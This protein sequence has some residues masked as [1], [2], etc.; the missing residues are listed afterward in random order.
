MLK[1]DWSDKVK[2]TVSVESLTRRLILK[3]DPGYPPYVYLSFVNLRTLQIVY[4]DG[5]SCQVY[6]L[7]Q[8]KERV[9]FK[10]LD[11]KGRFN[12]FTLGSFNFQR[13]NG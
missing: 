4:P 6:A 13:V 5:L 7:A 1:N 2:A 11:Y 12:Q 3:Q 8:D 10:H 9:K